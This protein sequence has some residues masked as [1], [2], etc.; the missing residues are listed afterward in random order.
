MVKEGIVLGNHILNKRI[1]VDEAKVDVIEKL[2]H[3]T[4]LKV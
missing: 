1:E 4:T 3:L 2:P